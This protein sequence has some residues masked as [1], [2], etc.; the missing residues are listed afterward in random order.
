MRFIWVD[1][2]RR[3]IIQ[4]KQSSCYESRVEN[5]DFLYYIMDKVSGFN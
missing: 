1:G 3:L 4:L 5:G 2:S